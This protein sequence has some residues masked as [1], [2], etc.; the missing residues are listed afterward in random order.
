MKKTTKLWAILIA[1]ILLL[2]AFA[3]SK[4]ADKPAEPT[5]A[6]VTE[7]PTAEPVVEQP[8]A[9]PVVEQPTEEPAPDTSVTLVDM[10][11][12]EVTLEKPAERIVALTASDCE[13]V[14]A[15]GAGDLLVGRGEYCDYPAEVF[16]V[17]SVESGGNTN[18]EQ[19]LALNP[20][21]VVMSSM[22]QTEEQVKQ[23]EDAG[24]AVV[25]NDAKDIAGVYTSIE[26]LGKLLGRDAEA[27]KIIEDMQAGFAEIE[28][29]K[30]DGTQTVYFEVSPLQWGLW[31]A[32]KGTF[33]NEI[34]EMMGLKN[35]FEDL[36]DWAQISEEQ[37]L[38]RNPDYIVTITM[39]WG[40]GP[41]PEE[42]IM[43]RP[44]W[45]NVTAVKNGAILNLPNNELSRPIPRLADGAKMLYDFVEQYAEALAPAA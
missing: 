12:H 30:L 27:Q 28:A 23:L 3:C 18:I 32:G 44:G 15:L 14:Y 25:V 43:S 4:P 5:Q 1:A 20:D 29:N 2:A 38:E 17:P 13:I 40:E 36:D 10:M 21:V 8:T 16:N 35:C 26:I 45:E 11:G 19:I 22:A 7:Q 39:Y 41:T 9:E 37:V 33:M 34:A 31:T 42:E 24:V 6:P